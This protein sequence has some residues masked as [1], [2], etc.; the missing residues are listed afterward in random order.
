MAKSHFSPYR[1]RSSNFQ[2]REISLVGSLLGQLELIWRQTNVCHQF[3]SVLRLLFRSG[4][5]VGISIGLT[6]LS[7]P[8]W[9]SYNILLIV[10]FS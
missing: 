9:T 6:Y 3:L 1:L 5:A 10:I 2:V 7:K 4:I 8:A